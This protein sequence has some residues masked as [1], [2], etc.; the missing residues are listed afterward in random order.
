MSQ[1]LQHSSRFQTPSK[2]IKIQDFYNPEASY[3]SKFEEGMFLKIQIKDIDEEGGSY[4]INGQQYP[5]ILGLSCDVFVNSVLEQRV[6]YYNQRVLQQLGQQNAIVP[7]EV[8]LFL[9]KEDKIHFRIFDC[10]QQQNNAKSSYEG[11]QMQQ[12]QDANIHDI[13]RQLGEKTLDYSFFQQFLNDKSYKWISFPRL[14]P[15]IVSSEKRKMGYIID[16]EE[17]PSKKLQQQNGESVT[18]VL[19]EFERISLKTLSPMKVKIE[20]GLEHYQDPLDENHPALLNRITDILTDVNCLKAFSNYQ[21]ISCE[22]QNQNEQ[23]LKYYQKCTQ[24]QSYLLNLQQAL[25]NKYSQIIS[26]NKSQNTPIKPNTKNEIV[27]VQQ[28]FI[29]P[30]KQKIQSI[31]A[32]NNLNNNN[33]SREIREQQEIDRFQRQ[34]NEN[35]INQQGRQ[36][37]R[38]ENDSQ[39]RSSR[40]FYNQQASSGKKQNQIQLNF[41]VQT[42]SYLFQNGNDNSSKKIV[43]QEVRNQQ[44][45]KPISVQLERTSYDEICDDLQKIQSDVVQMYDQLHQAKY[46]RDYIQQSPN[47]EAEL[48]KQNINDKQEKNEKLH[49][50]IN[51]YTD[52]IKQNSIIDSNI[53]V[54]I[55]TLQSIQEKLQEEAKICTEELENLLKKEQQLEKK[56]NRIKQSNELIQ[57]D[58]KNINDAKDNMK[59][60]NINFET[61]QNFKDKFKKTDLKTKEMQTVFDKMYE[62]KLENVKLEEYR[63]Q[64]KKLKMMKEEQKKGYKI[65][66]EVENP[67]DVSVNQYVRRFMKVNGTEIPHNQWKIDKDFQQEQIEED[68]ENEDHINHSDYNNINQ[69]ISIEIR[70]RNISEINQDLNNNNNN[71]NNND[72]TQFSVLQNSQQYNFEQNNQIYQE[73]KERKSAINNLLNTIYNL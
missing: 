46:L 38:L 8:T 47:L 41:D 33:D 10:I 69:D 70:K 4:K 44:I 62:Q 19:F 30:E 36:E 2:T 17:K 25:Y 54:R 18:K 27:L 9:A 59:K 53:D 40:N 21:L 61:L 1:K 6:K 72:I 34:S 57:I 15:S 16:P 56:V 22:Q 58:L 67:Q 49:K 50:I 52:R 28:I 73:I 71:N 66:C 42:Q 13:E 24:I 32:S 68:E 60:F 51:Q 23:Q 26:S 39:Q 3:S 63:N 65:F 20:Q 37:M 35:F 7:K 29:S 11:G 45:Q 64:L 12:N 55:N 14:V 48:I 43:Q 5:K 31:Q